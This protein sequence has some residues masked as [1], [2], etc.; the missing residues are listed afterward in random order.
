MSETDP[1]LGELKGR[2]KVKVGIGYFLPH[3]VLLLVALLGVAIFFGAER[4]WQSYVSGGVLVLLSL[5]F[6]YALWKTLPSLKDELTVYA[7]GLRYSGAKGIQSCT[8]HQVADMTS[9]IDSGNRL[10]AESIKKKNGETIVFA[11]KMRGLDLVEHLYS[12]YEFDRLDPADKADPLDEANEPVN[13]GSFIAEYNNVKS[14]YDYIPLG[15][16]LFLAA[17][18]TLTAFISRDIL[19]VGVCSLPTIVVFVLVARSFYMERNDVLKVFK[20]GFI[21]VSG[22]AEETCLWRDVDDYQVTRG[23]A[24]DASRLVAVRRSDGKWIQ[25]AGSMQGKD[26]LM[27]HMRTRV[28]FDEPER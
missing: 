10:K 24:D 11:Y 22:R 26:H 2:F 8:W 18:G 20:N 28:K 25:L 4:G 12:V 14:W 6:I 15:L 17:F 5:P 13:L 7:G 21:Y 23:R 9:I 19:A 16:T 1:K 3:T 27:P